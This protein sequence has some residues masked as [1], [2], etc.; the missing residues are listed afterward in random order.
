MG[1][2]GMRADWQL[3]AEAYALPLRRW[4]DVLTCFWPVIVFQLAILIVDGVRLRTEAKLVAACLLF[5]LYQACIVRW[6]RRMVLDERVGPTAWPITARANSYAAVALFVSLAWAFTA[7]VGTALLQFIPS[8]LDAEPFKVSG[9][10]RS[11]TAY[12]TPSLSAT[13]LIVS[14]DVLLT[15]M[16]ARWVVLLPVVAIEP[17]TIWRAYLRYWPGPRPGWRMTLIMGTTPATI[18]TSFV[19]PIAAS[20]VVSNASQNLAVQILGAILQLYGSLVFI[21][22]LSLWYERRER[23]GLLDQ[24]QPSEPRSN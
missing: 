1:L 16:L 2:A 22:T 7:I 5:W 15:F 4:K 18:A 24:L 11:R 13:L 10:T 20:S 9:S 21:T 23:R 6:L 12:P 14:A 17:Q 3:L 8:L 19:W